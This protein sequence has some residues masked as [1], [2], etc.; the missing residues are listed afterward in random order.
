[1]HTP[2]DLFS[3]RISCALKRGMWALH[4]CESC[5]SEYGMM[6][7]EYK[8]QQGARKLCT[9][10]WIQAFGAS[11]L[12]GTKQRH[13][14]IAKECPRCKQHKTFRWQFYKYMCIGYSFLGSDKGGSSLLT[15][16]VAT[17]SNFLV[18]VKEMQ[19]NSCSEQQQLK[20]AV[21]RFNISKRSKH[22]F[23]TST[24]DEEWQFPLVGS[25]G[26]GK[27]AQRRPKD[28]KHLLTTT[29]WKRFYLHL[30]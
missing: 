20:N 26:K 25:L 28:D 16:S 2:F 11:E 5:I 29:N 7:T 21:A 30:Q 1:M 9:E 13:T 14:S 6:S 24:I 4:D 23:T 27:A 15:C 3:F 18:L 10:W 8:E 17:C 12:H 19:G 22:T